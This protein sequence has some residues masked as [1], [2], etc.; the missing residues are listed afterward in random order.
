MNIA[1]GLMLFSIGLPMIMQLHLKQFE[2]NQDRTIDVIQIIGNPKDPT[3]P[4][5]EGFRLEPASPIPKSPKGPS[6]PSDPISNPTPN[7]KQTLDLPK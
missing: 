7:P 4:T 5:E 1:I 3:N 2:I 6:S